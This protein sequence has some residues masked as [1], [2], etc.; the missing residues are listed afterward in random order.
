MVWLLHH[1]LQMAARRPLPPRLARL[2]THS[3][4]T[5]ALQ[6]RHA[7][8]HQGPDDVL[9]ER[10]ARFLGGRTRS[11][12]RIAQ[13]LLQEGW[14]DQVHGTDE[15]EARLR[16]AVCAAASADTEVREHNRPRSAARQ[17]C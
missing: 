15:L 2:R 10:L 9:V 8:L 7:S 14:D 5:A 6:A 3:L 12:E 1:H 17:A 4:F 16:A 11:P 13:G